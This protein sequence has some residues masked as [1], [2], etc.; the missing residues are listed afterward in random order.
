MISLKFYYVRSRKYILSM[1]KGFNNN[2]NILLNVQYIFSTFFLCT[3][4]S[5]FY[6]TQRFISGNCLQI[7]G[8]VTSAFAGFFLYQLNE[9]KQLT[10][11]NVYGPS[12]VLLVLGIFTCVIGWLSWH[13]FDFTQKGQA[14][15]VRKLIYKYTNIDFWFSSNVIVNVWFLVC[16]KF[17]DYFPVRNERRNMGSCQT[18][19][20]RFSSDCSS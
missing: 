3:I 7:S 4:Q 11:E 13:F 16:Y 12:I 2:Q 6:F 15:L 18:W 20:N 19:T 17:G 14:I 8:V 9:Y 10:P 1:I 5:H